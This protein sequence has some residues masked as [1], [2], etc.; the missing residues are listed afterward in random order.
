MTGLFIALEGP[1]GSG[2]STTVGLLE[3]YLEKKGLDYVSTR[4]PGGTEIGEDI[5]SIILDKKNTSM[6]R[7]AEALLYA[8]SR[9]QHVSEKIRP[10][11]EAG[12]LVICDRFVWSSLAYQGVGRDIGIEEVKKI[13]D[14][15]IDGMY[16]DLILFFHIDPKVTLRRKTEDLA[17]DRLELEGEDFHDKVYGGYMSLLEKYP[18]NVKIIDATK[19]IEEVLTRSILEI[20]ELLKSKEVL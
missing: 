12:K 6:S 10:A 1:D 8:A 20:E 2:K 14:F 19:S 4:E 3:E 13:N 16:P 18:E 7:E 15:A 17:G 5:R 9:A 11:V